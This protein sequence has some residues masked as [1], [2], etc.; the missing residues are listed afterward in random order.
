V[1]ALEYGT[2]RLEPQQAWEKIC[3]TCSSALHRIAEDYELQIPMNFWS[4]FDSLSHPHGGQQMQ[5]PSQIPGQQGDWQQQ[6]GYGSGQ[7][8]TGTHS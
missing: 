7:Q 4:M 3:Q 1:Q 6:P 8:L 2:G 5:E